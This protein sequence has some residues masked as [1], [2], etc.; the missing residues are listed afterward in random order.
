MLFAAVDAAEI[1]SRVLDAA[2]QRGHEDAVPQFA[3][4]R[5]LGFVSQALGRLD[6]DAEP[7][8]V[9]LSAENAAAELAALRRAGENR[10]SILDRAQ[11]KYQALR[12]LLRRRVGDDA[13][14]A[15]EAGAAGVEGGGQAC[16]GS[17]SSAPAVEKGMGAAGTEAKGMDREEMIRLGL[18]TPFDEVTG[19]AA[20]PPVR[21]RMSVM[22]HKLAA[23][24]KV[25]ILD[26]RADGKKRKRSE[27]DSRGEDDWTTT[28]QRSFRGARGP[29]AATARPGKARVRG[30][31]GADEEE[32][33]SGDQ[34]S[35]SGLGATAASAA[36]AATSAATPPARQDRHRRRAD[37]P[38]S[39]AS[40]GASA[41]ADSDSDPRRPTDGSSRRNR[42]IRQR[43]EAAAAAA[44][45]VAAAG[46]AR[47]EVLCPVCGVSVSVTDVTHPDAALDAHLD[48]CL[49]KRPRRASASAAAAAGF[50][51]DAGTDEDEEIEES[52]DVGCT[53]G[54][55]GGRKGRSG[56]NVPQS[57]RRMLTSLATAAGADSAGFTGS[58][59][60]TVPRGSG[61]SDDDG[62]ERGP[63]GDQ[64]HAS[65]GLGDSS[66]DDGAQRPRGM[67]PARR[68][69][70]GPRERQLQ[71]R[72]KAGAATA[73]RR[74]GGEGGDD[75]SSDASS[76]SDGEMEN[77]RSSTGNGKKGA[78][79][80]GKA[81][82]AAAEAAAA[83]AATEL[84]G[85]SRMRNKGRA[86]GGL[87]DDFHDEDYEKRLANLLS[88]MDNRPAL[89]GTSGGGRRCRRQQ[90][91]SDGSGGTGGGGGG[92]DGVA[93]GEIDGGGGGLKDDGGKDG[94]TAAQSRGAD[95]NGA[96]GRSRGSRNGGGRGASSTGSGRGASSNGN[97]GGGGSGDAI[98]VDN[99]DD[100]GGSSCGSGSDSDDG[101]DEDVEVGDGLFLAR[102]VADRLF[103]Y[104]LTGLRWMWQL[105]RQ[106]AGGIVG[107]EMGL[108]KTVQ[109]AAFLGALQRGGWLRSAIVIAPAT[110][111]AHWAA[112]LH[113]WAPR[114]RV[115]VL[116][117]SAAAFNAAVVAAG[118]AAAARQAA[119]VRRALSLGPAVAVVTSYEGARAL[120]ERLLPH[121][122]DY[123]VLDEGQKIRNPDA[124]V[125]LLCKL[126]RTV[127]RLILTGTP[128]Q[129]NLIEL[130]SL[131]DF[132]FPGRL[133]TLPAFDAEF[134]TP[135]RVG[136]YANATAH[137]AQLA[138]RSAVVLRDL[139]DPY[140]LRRQ[141][142][143]IQEVLRLP[144]KTEQVL[145]CRLTPFQRRLYADY[146]T[147]PEV[148][149]V[150]SRD[151]RSFR[152]IGVLRKLCNHPDLVCRPGDSIGLQNPFEKREVNN[153]DDDDED[154][155]A[156]GPGPGP[157]WDAGW[158]EYGAPERS[159]KLLVLQQ[160]L[161]LWH[162][163]GHR[164]LLFS[165]TRMALDIVERFVQSC[166]WT[167]GR[168]DGNTPVGV[169]QGLIDAFN[170]D[171]GVFIMLLTTRTGGV[172]TNLT[173]AD[174]VLLFDPDWN[175]S[176]DVQ[177]RERAWRLGQTR[178]VTVYRLITAG[179]IEEKIYHRQIFKTAL[180]N[181]VLKDPKQK[182]LFSSTEL[183]ELFTLGNDGAI[184]GLTDTADVFKGEGN[185][186]LD[187]GGG[188]DS[189]RDRRRERRDGHRRHGSGSVHR[190]HCSNGGSRRRRDR[191]SHR[192]S[193]STSS[194]S[195]QSASGGRGGGAAAAAA[196]GRASPALED[197][198]AAGGAANGGCSGDGED[199]SHGESDVLRALFNGGP[200]TSIFAHDLAEGGQAALTPEQRAIEQAAR[201]A[202]QRAL[203]NLRHSRAA[204]TAELG[205]RGD[206]F[207]PTWTGRTGVG[208][209]GGSGSAG[210]GA[211][212]G[213]VGG[214]GSGAGRRF[215]TIQSGAVAA[216]AAAGRGGGASGT[217]L[218]GGSGSGGAAS[219]P[220]SSEL[221][222]RIQERR[223]R[224]VEETQLFPELDPVVSG[225]PPPP[226]PPMVPAMRAGG[227]RG[228][229]FGGGSNNDLT[230]RDDY[231]AA[232][233]GRLHAFF[234]E[235]PN[236]V[237]T[238]VV[239]Q[240]F[241]DVPDSDAAVFRQLLRAVAACREGKWSMRPDAN[242]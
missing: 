228:S 229:F 202:T 102:A 193:C 63:G 218:G 239:L 105:H 130:W 8:V 82:A 38:T 211:I 138:Y 61:G 69:L 162:R 183:R 212:A 14:K 118:T 173:G 15:D 20:R 35:A 119:L 13:D 94:G 205:A 227:S 79:G 238:A 83:E 36:A 174:R 62:E 140:L 90:R 4:A 146:I 32:F 68:R 214:S 60:E 47:A 9:R 242:L 196:S 56:G 187:G 109:V 185:V 198:E 65:D 125:T 168:L 200:L 223:R 39:A 191:D 24:G 27:P 121:P 167:Y 73:A 64:E 67:A 144:Q 89:V 112:E 81:A 126:L 186:I 66:D 215:G 128:I 48:R 220:S 127:H 30:P 216:A 124:D 80:K 96:R 71:P 46:A 91:R 157:A 177:A 160:I 100:A 141:K 120:R 175:P 237:E 6:A 233:L 98:E 221:L 18:M 156:A 59:S 165:Q 189:S 199:G 26:R 179:T 226:P 219:A 235:R 192:R 169:R 234:G 76:F 115:V 97:G 201:A 33:G 57:R 133:G 197:G 17:A 43:N 101:D 241:R 153:D 5:H 139:I 188:G 77:G 232:L 195:S 108:G 16:V 53:S 150:L 78:N 19:G 99:S 88:E 23:G 72:R 145:F 29:S 113:A 111:L 204:V 178:A 114:V 52:R 11:F 135:I 34:P 206:R 123:A 171:A 148:Q 159:G 22:E 117:R 51:A 208:A 166:G 74:G 84:N 1:E 37:E 222:R 149:R 40:E 152:A 31:E 12:A 213:S 155:A 209:S 163:E 131:F 161:P 147:S 93:N 194:D 224:Q 85:D 44:E 181:R 54:G 143:D 104:Q 176:T 3:P 154:G 207:L 225:S 182:R 240:R 92:N 7:A 236:G 217:G 42:T 70:A 129:N 170:G 87:V 137:Q 164:V 2:S 28:W 86:H 210:T 25:V 95:S 55:N 142:K 45:A 106:G 50:A 203:E 136:G 151:A 231:Y 49:R 190:R 184:D 21:P 122:W 107:D 41:G 158:G 103:Q 10:F 110:M 134:A 116:H 230:A 75:A 172:G 180:T 58:D 132:V